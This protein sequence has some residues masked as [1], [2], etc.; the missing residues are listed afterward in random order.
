MPL[1]SGQRK[2]NIDR[3]RRASSC[4]NTQRKTGREALLSAISGAASAEAAPQQPDVLKPSTAAAKHPHTEAGNTT[5]SVS[6]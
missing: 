2:R 4:H 5:R 6:K 3:Q 1:M